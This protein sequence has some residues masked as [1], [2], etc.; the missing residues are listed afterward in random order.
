MPTSSRPTRQAHL[1]NGFKGPSSGHIFQP[2]HVRETHASDQE[3]VSSPQLEDELNV[4]ARNTDGC[5]SIREQKRRSSRASPAST[6][7]DPRLCGKVGRT[8]EKRSK[9]G[10]EANPGPYDCLVS[11]SREQGHTHRNH[12][13]QTSKKGHRSAFF[14]SLNA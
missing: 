13:S 7:D 8:C 5:S 6:A 2:H 4:T 11:R 10:E 9:A 3:A 12:T 14:L 1:D